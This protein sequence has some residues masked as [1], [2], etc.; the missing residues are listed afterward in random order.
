LNRE[1]RIFPII[2]LILAVS[3]Y[4]FSAASARVN[5]YG[6]NMLIGSI[7]RSVSYGHYILSVAIET[8]VLGGNAFAVR[9]AQYF[10][11]DGGRLGQAGGAGISPTPAPTPASGVGQPPALFGG[12]G[13]PAAEPGDAAP[14]PEPQFDKEMFNVAVTAVQYAIDGVLGL[15]KSRFA[16]EPVP[17]PDTGGGRISLSLSGNQVPSLFSVCL[18]VFSCIVVYLSESA[19]LTAGAGLEPN[20]GNSGVRGIFEKMLDLG[21]G[22]SGERGSAPDIGAGTGHIA[23]SGPLEVSVDSV[24]VFALQTADSL[25]DVIDMI[26]AITVTDGKDNTFDVRLSASLS[27]EYM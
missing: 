4:A 19:N 17:Q 1:G 22:A 8:D 12:A 21:S 15:H 20:A 7:E 6:Y 9:Y 13:L 14:S 27:F 25:I 16:Y 23:Y 24:D 10:G 5:A 3:V 18:P 26:T 11:E 2:S